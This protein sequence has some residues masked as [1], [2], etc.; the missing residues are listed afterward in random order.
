MRLEMATAAKTVYSHI[1]KH[2]QVCGGRACIDHTR[3]RVLDIVCLAR[4]GLTPQQ[5]LEA[6]PS[7]NLAQMHAALSYAYEHPA[8][9][10]AT[11]EEDRQAEEMI[12]RERA[13]FLRGR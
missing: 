12:E 9:I 8:E 3:V 1:T 7:L 4:Q 5:M 11:L 6:Y 10:E 13:R 2:P